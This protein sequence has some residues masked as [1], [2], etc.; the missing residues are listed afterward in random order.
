MEYSGC[1]YRGSDGKRIVDFRKSNLHVMNYS[2]PVHATMPFNELRPHLFTI[3][4]HPDWIPYR[5][6]YYK[7]DWGFCLT[8]NQ[9]WASTNRVSTK[10]ALTLR[11]RMG[12]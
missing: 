3:P 7:E 10:C 9:M 2:A 6:S 1:V 8:H 5:T 4:E 12:T 11:S